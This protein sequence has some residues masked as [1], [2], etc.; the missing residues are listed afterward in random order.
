MVKYTQ[1]FVRGD[2]VYVARLNSETIAEIHQCNTF[3]DKWNVIMYNSKN[4]H[5]F[6]DIR[7]AQNFVE[8]FAQMRGK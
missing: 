8:T 5:E 1:R 7:S 6:N 3:I 4:Q 2:L